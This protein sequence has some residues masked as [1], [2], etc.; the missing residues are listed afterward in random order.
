LQK[1]KELEISGLKPTENRWD[2]IILENHQNKPK[3]RIRIENES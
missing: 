2:E 3:S 1:I